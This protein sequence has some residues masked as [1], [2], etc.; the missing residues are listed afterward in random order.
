MHS[1][2]RALWRL[3]LIALLVLP[4]H[5]VAARDPPDEDEP[6]DSRTTPRP[7]PRSPLSFEPGRRQ[8]LRPC[9]C[10]CSR[11]R[12]RR[13]HPSGCQ[14]HGRKSA[15]SGTGNPPACGDGGFDDAAV[16][17]LVPGRRAD[18]G[19][20]GGA[21]VGD[22]GGGGGDGRGD[23]GDGRGGGPR[24]APQPV[25]VPRTSLACDLRPYRRAH[26]GTRRH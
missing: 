9:R 24:C 25:S 14:A 18:G 7:V 4:A 16:Q 20:G 1:P 15:C 8:V 11:R 21:G 22:G 13:G 19:G 17:E 10:A 5:A 26:A 6:D 2:R 12:S 23:G 3:L